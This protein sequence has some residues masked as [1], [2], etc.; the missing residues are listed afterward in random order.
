[1]NRRYR[2]A[3]ELDPPSLWDHEGNEHYP[4]F[5]NLVSLRADYRGTDQNPA[6]NYLPS[7]YWEEQDLAWM[8]QKPTRAEGILQGAR[9]LIF[10]SRTLRSWHE[11][12]FTLQA[13]VQ[14]TAPQSLALAQEVSNS[15]SVMSRDPRESRS[16]RNQNKRTIQDTVLRFSGFREL[17]DSMVN[18]VPNFD[19]DIYA[20]G[21]DRDSWWAKQVSLEM[22]SRHDPTQHPYYKNK[23][24]D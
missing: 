22:P 19:L 15:I 3:H 11:W 7:L 12:S 13:C 4:G 17:L 21:Q 14:V 1:M 8:K 23:S 9:V 20:G 6:G 2:I 18:L 16:T 5:I 10:E 24:G